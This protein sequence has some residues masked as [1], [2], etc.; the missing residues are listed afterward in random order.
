MKEAYFGVLPMSEFK[1]ILIDENGD[2]KNVFDDNVRDF[3]GVGN[4]VNKDILKTLDK[5][6]SSEFSIL[7]NGVTIVA[8]DA[9]VTSSTFTIMDY[10]I[11]NGCQTSN[12]LYQYQQLND[13]DS[14]FIPIRL[15]VTADDELK[16]RVTVSTNNQ[17]TVKTEQLAAMSEFQ[18]NL[19]LYYS[20]TSGEGQLYYER[21]SK[22]YSKDKN[23]VKK[24]VIPISAQIKTF[25]SMFHQNP[26]IVT[27]YYGNLVKGIGKKGPTEIFKDGHSYSLYYLSGLTYYTLEELFRK[28]LI[29]KK[30]RKVK[31]YITM[32]IPMLIDE[33]KVPPLNSNKKCEEYMK[34]V[35]E[36]LLDQ[37]RCEELFSK[38]IAVIDGSDAPIEDKQALKSQKMTSQILDHFKMMPTEDLKLREMKQTDIFEA[39]N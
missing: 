24:R 18:K 28:S 25:S 7:N 34:K 16:S 33:G 32:L 4:P 1:S 31:F 12:V 2:V 20:S 38:A 19:E 17:T 35:S 14:I 36:I 5:E 30:Y 8:N 26:H 21:R 23:V 3:Q 11:V 15:I 10:Q 9:K 29:D 6:K 22:Q 27:T 39:L 37:P 13:I